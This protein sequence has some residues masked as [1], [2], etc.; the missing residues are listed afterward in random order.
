[1]IFP[2]RTSKLTDAIDKS[3]LLSDS[4]RLFD[5]TVLH[6]TVT[7]QKHGPNRGLG[8]HCP[9]KNKTFQHHTVYFRTFFR[10]YRI[11]RN[12]MN[13]NILYS[14]P[15]VIVQDLC[16]NW[17]Y[18]DE[19]VQ[20][21]KSI[22]EKLFRSEFMDILA[23]TI[24][25]IPHM[26]S[27]FNVLSFLA[28]VSLRKIRLIEIKIPLYT[29]LSAAENCAIMQSMKLAITTCEYMRL[30]IMSPAH[31]LFTWM[32]HNAPRLTTLSF[33]SDCK[34][35][36]S[37]LFEIA[38]STC[39]LKHLRICGSNRGITYRGILRIVKKF[40]LQTISL[41]CLSEIEDRALETIS[42]HCTCLKLLTIKDCPKVTPVGVACL[43]ECVA[44]GLAS[45]HF[46][47][48]YENT[49]LYSDAFN[50]MLEKRGLNLQSLSIQ[51]F[52]SS[53]LLVGAH[54]PNMT[55]LNMSKMSLN[56]SE[57]ELLVKGCPKLEQVYFIN[58]ITN[59]TSAALAVHTHL[60]YLKQILFM[61]GDSLLPGSA[62]CCFMLLYGLLQSFECVTEFQLEP[63][64]NAICGT[65]TSTEERRKFEPPVMPYLTGKIFSEHET[66]IRLWQ[67]LNS[68]SLNCTLGYC[69][70]LIFE[71]LCLVPLL[72]TN[73]K[74]L[75][76]VNSSCTDSMLS[77]IVGA[78]RHLKKLHLIDC[79]KITG[80]GW[81]DCTTIVRD[82]V[83]KLIVDCAKMTAEIVL[84]VLARMGRQLSYFGCRGS[85]NA[86][87]EQKCMSAI[88]MRR[89]VELVFFCNN[90]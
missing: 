70:S 22:C 66:N 85:S 8:S 41:E 59:P 23:D 36:N 6:V 11:K 63:T 7:A 20:L 57:F 32:V 64:C 73:L 56:G 84:A 2:F 25:F 47:S 3:N 18:M 78:N 71:L 55:Y 21:D 46:F 88:A 5:K 77:N 10:Q 65:V 4:R 74:L 31:N 51:G 16:V 37:T 44:K 48:S 68:L 76:L 67:K 34:L 40:T 54:C 62:N 86:H 28:W 35:T 83:T 30:N 87:M 75:S 90:A 53:G 52:K 13:G 80:P 79:N 38:K 43:A 81:I 26:R 29:I 9:T 45:I 50:Q 82:S 33:Q 69:E 58:Q 15:K 19:V 49:T 27:K 39:P 60:F 72:C 89:N 1:M 61:A 17:L 12:K 24:K 14:L 42:Q